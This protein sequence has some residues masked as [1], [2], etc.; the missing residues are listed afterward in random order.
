[1]AEEDLP[2]T[3]T[4]ERPNEY[5]GPEA[6]WGDDGRVYVSFKW[7]TYVISAEDAMNLG[8]EIQTAGEKAL[9]NKEE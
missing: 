1:M 7:D 3:M 2:D 9:D 5:S 4:D 8:E 6:E